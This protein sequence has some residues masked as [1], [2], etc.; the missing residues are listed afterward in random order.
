M[1]IAVGHLDVTIVT[2]REAGHGSCYA[3]AGAHLAI[4]IGFTRPPSGGFGWCKMLHIGVGNLY[5]T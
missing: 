5:T 1:G 2:G 4:Q 3:G